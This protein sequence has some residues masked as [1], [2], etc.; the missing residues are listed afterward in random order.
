MTGSWRSRYRAGRRRRTK[1]ELQKRA[2]CGGSEAQKHEGCPRPLQ[3]IGRTSPTGTCVKTGEPTGPLRH[4]DQ[5]RDNNW[6]N[7]AHALPDDPQGDCEYSS[8]LDWEASSKESPAMTKE[9]CEAKAWDVATRKPLLN[10][11]L[12]SCKMQMFALRRA[13]LNVLVL[14][15]RLKKVGVP[16][17]MTAFQRDGQGAAYD[18]LWPGELDAGLQWLTTPGTGTSRCLQQPE[19]L[20]RLRRKLDC[21]LR[22]AAAPR[23]WN[24]DVYSYLQGLSKILSLCSKRPT[25]SSTGALHRRNS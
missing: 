12:T 5:L 20:W 10:P 4:Q 11:A 13:T 23:A 2:P 7:Y 9:P 22:V 16:V 17:H 21:N 1:G 25:M 18:G 24:E 6:W 8:E 15:K 14:L 19:S 3:L